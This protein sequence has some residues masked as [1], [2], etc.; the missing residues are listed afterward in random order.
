MC[1]KS[2]P[3]NNEVA[4]AVGDRRVRPSTSP[5]CPWCQGHGDMLCRGHPSTTAHGRGQ[6][7]S[8]AMVLRSKSRS[9]VQMAFGGNRDSEESVI[10]EYSEKYPSSYE[11]EYEGN[12][13]P[14]S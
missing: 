10:L 2:N 3:Q 1:T 14:Q 9:F 7:R 13:G 6:R 8:N 11:Y 12:V 4:Q 5:R